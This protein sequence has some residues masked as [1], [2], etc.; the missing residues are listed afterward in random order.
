MASLAD[1]CFREGVVS[2]D[3]SFAFDPHD[4]FPG[5]DPMWLL[6]ADAEVLEP[7]TASDAKAGD[8]EVG[9]G[10][11]AAEVVEAADRA[12]GFGHDLAAQER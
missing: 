12:T 10:E 9:G 7:G 11:L 8:V 3:D 5:D 6:G 1:S 4:G 2:Y